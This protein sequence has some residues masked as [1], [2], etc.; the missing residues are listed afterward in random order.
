MK[1]EIKGYIVMCEHPMHLTY[2]INKSNFLKDVPAQEILMYAITDKRVEATLFKNRRE[3]HK[4]AERT[5][6]WGV[7]HGTHF[8]IMEQDYY[9]L[10]VR[11]P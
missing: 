9:I 5:I 4:A 7:K 11:A 1:T 10:I 2:A 6:S 3:A 8:P